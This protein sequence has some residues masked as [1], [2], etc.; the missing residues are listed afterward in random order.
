MF[1][2]IVKEGTWNYNGSDLKIWITIHSIAF[3]SGDC[4]DLEEIQKDKKVRTYYLWI[5][6]A[7]GG[8]PQ[9]GGQFLSIEGAQAH[10]ENL[11][12]P[13]GPIWKVI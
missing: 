7:S 12:K 9:G 10:A 8:E 1:G 5:E 6:P 2:K 3:G 11:M 4:E 13:Q